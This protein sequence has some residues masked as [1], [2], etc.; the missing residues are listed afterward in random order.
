MISESEAIERIL[1]AATPLPPERLPVACAL[2]RR[3]AVDV[4]SP[5]DLPRFNQSAMD[6][7]AIR[8]EDATDELRI[9]GEQPAG[10]DRNLHVGEGEA[11]R[12][13]TGAPVPSGANSVVMQEDVERIGNRIRVRCEVAPGEFIRPRGG[14]LCA[15]QTVLHA[16][17]LI[18]AAR[19]G[20]LVSIGIV[21]IEVHRLP[22]IGIVSTGDELLP[23][24]AVPAPGESIDSNTPML[25]AMLGDIGT[26]C[27]TRH[28][29]D[30]PVTLAETLGSLADADVL[31]LSGGAS[32]GD[33]DP[34]HAAL[35]RLGAE[36]IFWKVDIKP[37]RPLL[38]ARWEHRLIF[39]LP[40][41]PVSSFVAATL[42]VRP[43]LLR[44]GGTNR[45][46]ALPRHLHV[47][48]ASPASNPGSRP[49]YLR[50]IVRDGHFH[51]AQV[52]QSHGLAALA[53]SNA[54][55]RLNPNATLPAE[56]PIEVLVFSVDACS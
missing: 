49:H 8:A 10:R 18:N 39:G 51:P 52:Q 44:L 36:R 56:T 19:I 1:A 25:A 9:T 22:R 30:D 48:L 26:I 32:V 7:Y 47:P 38:F 29:P 20:L 2:R 11:V 17:D 6:G 16:G 24:G 55:A 14:D 45:Q 21:E 54:V 35:D 31:V 3:A 50:G 34:V 28:S 41:N 4:H 27:A 12:I 43:A 13:F 40:G 15:G 5:I 53:A 23:A 46:S 42:F 37:G 33:H